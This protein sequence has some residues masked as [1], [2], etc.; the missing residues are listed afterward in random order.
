MK[1]LPLWFRLTRWA[2]VLGAGLS[3]LIWLATVPLYY[4]ATPG[5]NHSIRIETGRINYQY[6]PRGFNEDN[7]IAANSEAMRWG[8]DFHAYP[9]GSWFVRLPLWIPTL[10]FDSAAVALFALPRR[11]R[12]L[13]RCGYALDGLAATA[14]VV[15]CPECGRRNELPQRPRGRQAR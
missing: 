10:V 8:L 1:R 12:G 5:R 7:G 9:D 4:F 11:K 13:C 2:C 3:I 6:D 14:G 15:T